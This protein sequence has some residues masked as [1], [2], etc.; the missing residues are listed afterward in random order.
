MDKQHRSIS[1]NRFTIWSKS[2]LLYLQQ[3]KQIQQQQGRGQKTVI[4]QQLVTGNLGQ[5]GLL[6]YYLIQYLK[7]KVTVVNFLPFRCKV[8]TVLIFI[9]VLCFDVYLK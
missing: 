9:F 5:V 1:R 2:L 3:L 8:L 6:S 7:R 4:A